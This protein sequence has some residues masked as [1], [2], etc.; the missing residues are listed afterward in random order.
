MLGAIEPSALPTLAPTPPRK[1]SRGLAR[2]S[3]ISV[4]ILT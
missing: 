1:A 2:V 4:P 3:A